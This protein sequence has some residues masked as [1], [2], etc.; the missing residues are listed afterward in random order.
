VVFFAAWI[1]FLVWF[2]IPCL[3]EIIQYTTT[4]FAET[5]FVRGVSAL[6]VKHSPN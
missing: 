2:L 4:F 3:N 6:T 1:I 5:A